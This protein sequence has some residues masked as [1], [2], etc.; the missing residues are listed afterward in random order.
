MPPLHFSRGS[1]QKLWIVDERRR[2]R[3]PVELGHRSPAVLVVLD[4]YGVLARRKRQLLSERR[5][6]IPP[7]V[8]NGRRSDLYP[9]A[10]VRGGRERVGPGFERR[11]PGPPHAKPVRGPLAA[12]AR[13]AG[14]PV[15]IERPHPVV[16]DHE[17][18]SPE[19][20]PGEILALPA[21]GR[22]RG[23]AAVRWSFGR[24]ADRVE[25]DLAADAGL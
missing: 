7:L 23:E 9:E 8:E 10:I 19:R 22:D 15:E 5:M 21:I 18:S 6:L 12:R 11:G 3:L 13:R 25:E 14:S 24:E 2:H 16:S 4:G 20:R 1:H 17:R